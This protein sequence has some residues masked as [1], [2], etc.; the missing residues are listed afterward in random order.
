[1]VGNNDNNDSSGLRSIRYFHCFEKILLALE[2]DYASFKKTIQA[3]V[4]RHGGGLEL[5]LC[6]KHEERIL[7]LFPGY[8]GEQHCHFKSYSNGRQSDVE[9][10][11]RANQIELIYERYSFRKS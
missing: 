2:G 5:R 9:F 3:K 6:F 8:L 10:H 4:R 7:S 1:M 11:L